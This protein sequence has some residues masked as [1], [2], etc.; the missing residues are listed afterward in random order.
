MILLQTEAAFAQI[1][2][3]STGRQVIAFVADTQAP[4][5]IETVFIHEDNNPKATQMVMSEILKESPSSLFMLGDVVN[6]GPSI[7]AW[8]NIDVFLKEFKQKNIPYYGLLGNHELMKRPL[9]G[10]QNFQHYFPD[11]VR[12]GYLEIVDSVAI[13]LMNSNSGSLSKAEEKLQLQW[14]TKALSDLDA[15][16]AVKTVIVTCHHPPFTNSR[17][18]NPSNFV[19][20]NFVPGF[21]KSKKAKLFLTGHSHRFEYFR[22][23][24][25]DFMV[26]GGGGGLNH[27]TRKGGV[28]FPDLSGDYKPLFHY[29]TIERSDDSL[30]V[31]S[32]ALLKD[33][34]GFENGFRIEIPIVNH[35]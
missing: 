23:E 22:Y 35:D 25:K 3:K 32:H 16:R 21:I 1:D 30:F 12:T 29:L 24:D 27:P 9:K 14:Y 28:H 6:M 15:N 7:R 11:H 13:L 33:F 17:L 5:W 10:E 20:E 8:R 4:M 31:Q 26:I 18:V 34:S 2:K 19:Q